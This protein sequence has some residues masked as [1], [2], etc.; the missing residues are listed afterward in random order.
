M[1]T[2]FN[3]HRPTI[4]AKGMA[5]VALRYTVLSHVLRSLCTLKECF[6]YSMLTTMASQYSAANAQGYTKCWGIIWSS[7]R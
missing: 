2:G 6:T 3:L 7:F 1:M 4:N 5:A